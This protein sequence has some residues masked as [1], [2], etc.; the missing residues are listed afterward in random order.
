MSGSSGS[1]PVGNTKRPAAAKKWCFTYNNYD[2]DAVKSVKMTLAPL[3]PKGAYQQEDGRTAEEPLKRGTPH[4]QG[5]V[6][7]RKKCRPK[8]MGILPKEVHWESTRDWGASVFYCTD[9]TKRIDDGAVIT[10]GLP[11]GVPYDWRVTDLSRWPWA[12]AAAESFTDWPPL[13]DR[14][15]HWYW[16]TSGETGKS[17]LLRYLIDNHNAMLCG[18]R[19]GDIAKCLEPCVS[20]GIYHHCVVFNLC[21]AQHN[22][23]SYAGLEALKDGMI[24]SWKN[25]SVAL[26]FP[27]PHVVVVANEPP[28]EE[29]LESHVLRFKVTN[30]TS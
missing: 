28:P 11:P 30:V 24:F 14:Y 10:W 15:V 25:D 16:S 8:E 18:G 23:V 22:K 9:P 26:R 6:E 4:L 27:A 13:G 29:L 12:E 1:K 3:A 2:S 19:M 21:R 5:V 7:F 20:D 17:Q